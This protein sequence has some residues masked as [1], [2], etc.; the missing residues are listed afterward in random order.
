MSGDS[1]NSPGNGQTLPTTLSA[2]MLG[3]DCF[4]MDVDPVYCEIVIRRLERFRSTGKTGWQNSNPFAV[5]VA[6]DRE[7]SSLVGPGQETQ[8]SEMPEERGH[9][10]PPQALLFK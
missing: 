5:E 9:E 2:E 1:W 10:A 7:L 8:L 4:T 3:R 6:E